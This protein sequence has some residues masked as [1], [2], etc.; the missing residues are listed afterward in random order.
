MKNNSTK[1]ILASGVFD[2]LHPGHEF[3]LAEAAKL[4]TYLVVVVAADGHAERTKRPPVND[5]RE[6]AAQ[7][8]SLAMVDE[9]LIGANPFDLITTTRKANP[10]I[11]A[12][13][14]DQTFDETRLKTDLAAAGIEVEVVRIP[15][16]PGWRQ[17]TTDLLDSQ[18]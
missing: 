12:L 6:R 3:Y 11:I 16:S 7:I 8:A 1:R 9:V 15:Q 2:I 18:A 4:G 10:D 13:G 5:E 14:H 17:S